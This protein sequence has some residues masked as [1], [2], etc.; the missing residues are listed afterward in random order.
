M[1][2]IIV[3]CIFLIAFIIWLWKEVKSSVTI[4]KFL[5]I[6]IGIVVIMITTEL[7]W[8]YNKNTKEYKIENEN[9]FI[10]IKLSSNT[11]SFYIVDLEKENIT[12]KKNWN[13][14]YEDEQNKFDTTKADFAGKEKITQE[15]ATKL[16]DI[17]DGIKQNKEANNKITR[18]E[19]EALYREKIYHYYEI[20]DV[21]QQIYCIKEKKM[22]KEFDKIIN[23]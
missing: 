9:Q 4:K 19:R 14:H 5:M 17:I 7:M 11:S 22:I 6:W 2:R 15:K 20:K 23:E 21:H 16:R 13:V 1:K 10:I 3:S 18:E 8:I 12:K